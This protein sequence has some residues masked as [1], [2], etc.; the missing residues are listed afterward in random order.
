MKTSSPAA[1]GREDFGIVLALA[2][3]AFVDELRAFLA[4]QGY[5]NL[6]RSFGYVARAL[7]E[8][9]LTLRELAERLELT[10]QGALKIVD[11]MERHGYLERRPDPTDARAKLLALTRDGRRALEAARGF[12][13]SFEAKLVE[14]VGTRDVSALRRSLDAMIE[15][16]HERGW[17]GIVRPV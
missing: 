8:H 1:A 11:D 2:Y 5:A 12:H 15:R 13:R 14:L 9:P 16:A 10:S 3:A 4:E 7:V 6:N 17:T